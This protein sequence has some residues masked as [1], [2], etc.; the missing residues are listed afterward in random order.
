MAMYVPAT[1]KPLNVFCPYCGLSQEHRTEE[2]KSRVLS[3]LPPKL[4]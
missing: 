2:L 4:N 3:D 1:A